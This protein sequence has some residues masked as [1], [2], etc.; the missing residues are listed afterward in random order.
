V[1][2]FTVVVVGGGAS[3]LSAAARWRGGPALNQQVR[4]DILTSSANPFSVA[5]SDVLMHLYQSN[6]GD[7]LVSGYN[8]LNF[9]VSSLF[10]A[11]LGNTLRLRFAEVDNLAQFQVGVDNV[12]LDDVSLA[13][14]PEPASLTLLGTSLAALCLRRRR[15]ARH[16]SLD[17]LIR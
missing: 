1:P 16:H 14:V 13:A 7:P 3:G 5:A 10:A 8:S 17:G 2:E 6:P 9:D 15:S 11:N 4:V 12:S